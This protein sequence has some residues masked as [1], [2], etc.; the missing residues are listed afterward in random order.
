V[1]VRVVTAAVAG[2]HRYIQP[3]SGRF[4]RCRYQPTCSLYTVEAVHKY[5]I[6][7]G[8]W[9]GIRRIASCQKSVPM[10]TKDPVP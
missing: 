8:S 5:G 4:I 2:Y 6:A 10:G 7:K 1:S 3:F 9:M